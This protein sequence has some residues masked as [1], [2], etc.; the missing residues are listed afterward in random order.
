MPSPNGIELTRDEKTL[1]IASYLDE[2]VYRYDV[3]A[4]GSLGTRRVFLGNIDDADSLCL[5]AAGNLYVGASAGLRIYRPDASAVG[6][7]A[8]P[9]G[10][11][12]T[13]CA[14]GGAD[15]RTLYIT[16][17]KTLWSIEA[18]PIPGLEWEKHQSL[19]CAP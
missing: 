19:P 8:M 2:N 15:G 18:M 5:D 14:F 4:D 7:I 10:D 3:A 13:N 12:V 16:A 11:K 17:W 9:T 6:T 1:Y